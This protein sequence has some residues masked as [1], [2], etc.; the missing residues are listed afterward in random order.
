MNPQRR[1][2]FQL[3][4]H[5]ARVALSKHELNRV[6][7]PVGQGRAPEWPPGFVGSISH[8]H[9]LALA[10]A[11]PANVVSGLGVDIELPGALEPAMIEVICRP[12]EIDRLDEIGPP[13]IAARLLFSAKESVYKC[14]W[15]LLRRYVDFLDVGLEIDRQEHSFRIAGTSVLPGQLSDF[16]KGRY[17]WSGGLLATCAYLDCRG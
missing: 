14:V 5:C 4:R 13:E 1:A 6:E 11:G 15:P 16:L 3:G 9:D 7:L 8:T 17:D 12:E 2:L 10:A